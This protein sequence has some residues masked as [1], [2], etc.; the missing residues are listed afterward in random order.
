MNSGW[1]PRIAYIYKR[2]DDKEMAQVDVQREDIYLPEF[3]SH[4]LIYHVGGFIFTLPKDKHLENLLTPKANLINETAPQKI[5]LLSKNIFKFPQ[6]TLVKTGINNYMK[7]LTVSFVNEI[8]FLYDK[9]NL[10]KQTF[11]TE[12][13][14]LLSIYGSI[15]YFDKKGRN[16][17]AQIISFNDPLKFFLSNDTVKNSL[18]FKLTKI[19]GSRQ[20]IKDK[21]VYNFSFT[22]IGTKRK[23]QMNEPIETVIVRGQQKFD[24]HDILN[25]IEIE[26]NHDR[27]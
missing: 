15:S 3:Y 17:T 7:K 5:N 12:M 25:P 4:D 24:L 19:N 16:E 1:F 27:I 8:Y 22:E 9:S 10:I 21:K 6:E 11:V 23:K 26:I 20:Q 13:N 14:K 2:R 18:D